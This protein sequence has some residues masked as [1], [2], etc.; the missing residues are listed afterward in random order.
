M[1]DVSNPILARLLAR[2]ST[3]S[4]PDR[5]MAEDLRQWLECKYPALLICLDGS[6]GTEWDQKMA[7]DLTAAL[8]ARK[9]SRTTSVRMLAMARFRYRRSQSHL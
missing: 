3:V 4:V 5:E 2:N 9:G 6:S 8:L 7:D 1:S